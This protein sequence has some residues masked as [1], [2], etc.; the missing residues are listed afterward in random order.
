MLT[1]KTIAI[2]GAGNGGQSAAFELTSKGF[3]VH[4]HDIN[5]KIIEGIRER[6]GIRAFGQLEG[7]A[8]IPLATTD[9]SEA[10]DGAEAILPMVPRFVHGPLAARLSS[11]LREDQH[12]L[13]CPGST[14][15]ELEFAKILRED[16]KMNPVSTVATLPYAARLR[17]SG[18]VFV[19][20]IAKALFFSSFPAKDADAESNYFQALFPALSKMANGLEV[21]LNN[22]N[23]VTHPAP[24]LLNAARI[25][26]GEAFLFYKEGITPAIAKINE[27][28]DSERLAV[29]RALGFKEIPLTERL[30]LTGY[31]DRIYSST[32]EAYHSSEAF[33]PIGAPKSLKDRYILED[34]PYGLVT[35]ASLADHL[36]VPTP[37]M[38]LVIRLASEIAGINF[39]ERGITLNAMGL[40][41]MDAAELLRF[42][43]T[44]KSPLV[45]WSA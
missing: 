26:R 25:E 37:I 27:K 32:L 6:G 33:A 45:S 19:S 20:L 2:I 30:F 35:F 41:R 29:C 43:E 21:G 39:W 44:G 10:I 1:H 12:I 17:E 9:L 31:A 13:L 15:G 40:D 4:I 24:T 7:F 34:I 36:N 14:A 11:C 42:V 38:Q 16:G 28:L 18:E 23:P 3:V 22:G 8:R 5:Q